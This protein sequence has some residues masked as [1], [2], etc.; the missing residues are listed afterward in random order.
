MRQLS[1]QCG[2]LI[3]LLNAM[4]NA[5]AQD[6]PAD[7]DYYG[8]RKA[9]LTAIASLR[10]ERDAAQAEVARLR[11]MLA[12][13]EQFFLRPGED[14]NDRFERIGIAFHAETRMLRPGKDCRLHSSEVRQAAWDKWIAAHLGDTRAALESKT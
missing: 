4:E 11:E 6:K 12:W 1:E 7:H 9:V 3:Y 14:E 10:A 13:H 2:G 5:A 8:K